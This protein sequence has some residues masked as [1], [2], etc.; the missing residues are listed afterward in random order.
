ME[1]VIKKQAICHK[2]MQLK[3]I[4]NHFLLQFRRYYKLYY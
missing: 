2:E 4:N 1:I 3:I